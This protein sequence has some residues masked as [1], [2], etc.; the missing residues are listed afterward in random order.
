MNKEK[1][2]NKEK[3]LYNFYPTTNNLIY[4]KNEKN[5]NDIKNSIINSLICYNNKKYKLYKNNIVF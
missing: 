5:I 4:N 2:M 3:D 1:N